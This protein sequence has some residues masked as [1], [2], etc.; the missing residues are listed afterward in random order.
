MLRASAP[1]ASA[2]SQSWC[3]GSPQQSGSQDPLP[4]H[5]FGA[6]AVFH[7]Q[8]HLLLSQACSSC[9]HLQNAQLGVRAK[10]FQSRLTLRPQEP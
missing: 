10:L 4:P 5:L 1:P 6:T 7:S 3:S 8:P 9:L 2:S